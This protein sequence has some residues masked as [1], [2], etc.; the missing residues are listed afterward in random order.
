MQSEN[1]S[2][3]VEDSVNTA[4][5]VQKGN[6]QLKQATEKRSQAQ[7]VFW[8]TSALCGFLVAWDLIF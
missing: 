5:N 2:Q 8:A 4:D 1:I 3:L 6:K 7:M